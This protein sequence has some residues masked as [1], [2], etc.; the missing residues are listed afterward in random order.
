[1]NLNVSPFSTCVSRQGVSLFESGQISSCSPGP[2]CIG[3]HEPGTR[4]CGLQAQALIVKAVR[5]HAEFC[6][7]EAPAR[8]Y[9][10]TGLQKEITRD[11]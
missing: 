2:E 1:H 7:V 8:Q 11:D 9:L 4:G 5:P 10:V 3:R 6:A